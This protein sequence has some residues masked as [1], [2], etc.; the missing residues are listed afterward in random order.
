LI[1]RNVSTPDVEIGQQSANCFQQVTLALQ[2]KVASD[3]G[4]DFGYVD[5]PLLQPLDRC[6]SVTHFGRR[7]A[8]SGVADLPGGLLQAAFTRPGPQRL[9][10][11]PSGQGIANLIASQAF[12]RIRGAIVVGSAG[13]KK[14]RPFRP[15]V[16]SSSTAFASD[17][18]TGDSPESGSCD[19]E[20]I[21]NHALRSDRSRVRPSLP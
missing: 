15:R 8:A 9:D 10:V 6:F 3:T 11:E 16:L 2:R 18:G 4:S 5:A 1:S 21:A 13:G 19:G 7:I 17:S 20:S 14:R 12:H